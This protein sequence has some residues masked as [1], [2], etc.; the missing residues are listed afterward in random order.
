MFCAFLIGTRKDENQL[1]YYTR[2]IGLHH[3]VRNNIKVHTLF[4]Y[5]VSQTHFLKFVLQ[6][7]PFRN[8]YIIH[9]HIRSNDYQPHTIIFRHILREALIIV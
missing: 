9:V 7:K 8:I 1:L 6:N 5:K 4:I 2:S 3:N